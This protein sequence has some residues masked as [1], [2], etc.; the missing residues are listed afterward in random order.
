MTFQDIAVLAEERGFV[1]S[2]SEGVYRLRLKRTDGINVE[3]SFVTDGK[4]KVEHFALP[5]SWEY[6]LKN[7]QT[8]EELYRDWIEHYGEE[9]PTERMTSLQ[10]EIYDFVNKV[11]RLE[12]R[13]HEYPVFSILGWKVGKIK[14]LQF[15]TD[16]GWRDLWGSETNAA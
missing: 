6:V 12:I 8:G 4:N 16:S 13:I 5:Y 2:Q 9:T 11:S 7:D 10:A 3:T 14:E 1:V 15:K